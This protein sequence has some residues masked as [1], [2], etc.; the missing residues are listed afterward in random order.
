MA[1][2][3]DRRAKPM[4]CEATRN[5][6]A[7][8]AAAHIVAAQLIQPP[9]VHEYLT[10]QQQLAPSSKPTEQP[11]SSPPLPV[12]SQSLAMQPS[13]MQQLPPAA[14]TATAASS[15]VAASHASISAQP[16]P[17]PNEAQQQHQQQRQVPNNM[18]SLVDSPNV[19]GVLAMRL[20]E[21]ERQIEADR[22]E[23]AALRVELAIATER[24]DSY[25][26]LAAAKDDIIAVARGQTKEWRKHASEVLVS[27]AKTTT[28][29][30]SGASSKDKDKKKKK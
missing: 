1:I 17:A 10:E 27:G 19:E 26:A 22:Q 12:W 4:L 28:A 5:M 18:S 2:N 23:I 16:P 11:P 6:S 20:A 29:A 30:V 9:H 25:K 13:L 21:A 3:A 14:S 7:G 15:Q 24:A 8:A